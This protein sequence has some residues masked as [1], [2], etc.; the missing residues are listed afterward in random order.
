MDLF[1][2][3][4]AVYNNGNEVNMKHNERMRACIE[5]KAVDRPPVALWKHYP[6]D[7]MQ[8]KLWQMPIYLF[9]LNTILT[10]LR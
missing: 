5:G 9:R 10:S 6:V 7:D 4:F 2:S 8:A 3:S 1:I